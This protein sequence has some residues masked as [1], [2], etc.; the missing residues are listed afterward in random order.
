MAA[1]NIANNDS[2][3]TVLILEKNEYTLQDYKDKNHNDIFNWQVAQNDPSFNYAFVYTDNESVWMGKGLGGGT[4]H[5]GLQYID[6]DDLVN[7]NFSEWK[8]NDGENIVNSVNA[9]TQATQNTYSTDGTAHSPNEVYYDLKE[10]ID[11]QTATN[12]VKSYNNKIY[13]ILIYKSS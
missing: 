13:K 8:N 5:F 2:N 6:T 1:Y 4:L 7:H 12:N 3:A 10:Y 9:I 11:S